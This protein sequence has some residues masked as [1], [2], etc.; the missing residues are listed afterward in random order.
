MAGSEA[1]KQSINLPF[2]PLWIAAS[3][4]AVV[5][6]YILLLYLYRLLLH[7][8]ARYPGPK[9]AAISN[10][11]EFYYEIILDGAFTKHLQQLH[12]CYGSFASSHC[13]LSA[14]PRSRRQANNHLG[15]IVRISPHELHIDDPEFYDTMYERSGRRDRY[16]YFSARFG[17]ASDTFSTVEHEDHR[18]RRKALSPMFSAKRITEFQPVIRAKTDK[19]CEKL[20]EYQ[21]DGR[22][23]PMG[24]A[25][26]ALTTDIITEYAFA[27]SYNH[28]D[29]PNF[30]DT[31]HEALVAIYST[32][33]FALHFPIVFPILD[34]LP[35]WFV[36]RVQP[37]LQPV[38][39]M[40]K[41]CDHLF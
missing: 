39:G 34:M 9:L 28:L 25:W 37:V 27:N 21:Q 8:L 16:R 33:Q 32:G 41:V 30:K 38:V 20:R 14:S 36:L 3:I 2:S 7:P 19:L 18:M 31:M 17:F 26:M 1:F 40:R 4:G 13:E 10:W 35:D 5:V 6:T 12:K 24:R 11:Y 23:L 29:S 15:S 22:V